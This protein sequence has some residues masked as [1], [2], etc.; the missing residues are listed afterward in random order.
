MK[1]TGAR[2]NGKALSFQ[3]PPQARFEMSL[4]G[5]QTAKLKLLGTPVEDSPWELKRSTATA[6]TP[7]PRLHGAPQGNKEQVGKLSLQDLRR[8]PGLL[9]YQAAVLHAG[10]RRLSPDP[11]VPTA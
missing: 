7:G 3:A 6:S 8:A 10:S 1:I 9:P 5:D 4:E 2:T 11:A